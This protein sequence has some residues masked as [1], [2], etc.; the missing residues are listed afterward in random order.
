ME[1]MAM[2]FEKLLMKNISKNELFFD[3]RVLFF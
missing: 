1:I 3:L 2:D